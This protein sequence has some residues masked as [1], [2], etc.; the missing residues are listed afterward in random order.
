[1]RKA[2]WNRR[3]PTVLGILLIVIG[4][5]ITTFLVK[6]GTL[7]NINANPTSEPT[8]VRISNITDTSFTVSYT[9]NASVVGSL[10]YGKDTNLGQTALDEKD[11][12]NVSSH[13]IHSITVR[14]LSPQ[15]SYLFTIVS[16]SQTYLNEGHPFNVV[17]GVTIA[18]PPPTQ[19]PVNGKVIIPSGEAPTES[20]VYLTL[21]NS[22]VISTPVKP[23]GSYILPLNSLRTND[24]SSYYTISDS[25]RLKILA[26]GDSLKSNVLLTA[27]EISPVPV[28]TLS[29]DFDFTTSSSPVA[30]SSGTIS[31]F[32]SFTS[33]ESATQNATPQILTPKTDQGFSDQQ[34]TFKGTAAPNQTVQIIIHSQDSINTKITTDSGGRWS[35]RPTTPLSPGTH[36]ITIIAK[37]ASGILRTINQSFVVYAAGQQINPGVPSGSPTPIPPTST[38]LSPTITVTKSPT[39]TVTVTVS[40]TSTP[41][42]TLILSPIPTN[43][44]LPPTGNSSIFIVGVIGAVLTLV[45]GLLFLLARGSATIL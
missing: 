27:S 36:T 6:T 26:I 7:L 35:Y 3:I 31:S 16:A 15:T 37:D 23:D 10:S 21:D 40:I 28:I 12:Q 5:S 4:I 30:T 25:S 1:M 2:F 34:P 22:Q 9:T 39:P 14:S 44:P 24:L 13:K 43:K 11:Q 19:N 45:G 33:T 8:E 41:S 18:S 38:P 42:E 17:T 20:I 29:K 32:P